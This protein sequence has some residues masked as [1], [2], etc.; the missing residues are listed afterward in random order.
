MPRT[1]AT[2]AAGRQR[3]SDPNGAAIT[4]QV[5]VYRRVALRL[6]QA[7]VLA[8]AAI[9]QDVFNGGRATT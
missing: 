3:T 6:R 7:P 8:T 5:D 1:G 4:W 2:S 9:L